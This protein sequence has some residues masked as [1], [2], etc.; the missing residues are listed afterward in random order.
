MSNSAMR[1]GGATLFLATF[2]L[3]RMPYFLGAALE[4][5]D[6]ADVEPHRGVE[7]QGVAAVVVSGLP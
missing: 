6:A 3:A 2:T 7:L 5:L 4:G 1:N